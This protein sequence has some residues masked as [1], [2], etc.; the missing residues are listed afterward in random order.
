MR[1]AGEGEFLSNSVCST[2]EFRIVA[3]LALVIA[4]R[5]WLSRVVVVVVVSVAVAVVVKKNLRKTSDVGMG[6]VNWTLPSPQR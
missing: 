4:L 5:F 3:S 1:G 2:L 6:G